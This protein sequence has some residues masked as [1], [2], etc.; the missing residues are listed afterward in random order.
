MS[1]L[2][3]VRG[4]SHRF[5]GLEV[6]KDVSFKIDAGSI[7]GLI[8]PNGAGKST[9]FNIISGFLTP[10]AGLVLYDGRDVSGVPV[11][12][13]SYA[14]LVRTF[15]TPQVF[16]HL[17]V[18]ENLIAGGYKQTRSGMLANLLGTPPSRADMARMR[19]A[20]DEACERFG[21]TEVRHR[22]AGKLPGGQQRL[23][24]LAR[25]WVGRPR[26]LCLDEPSS[27]LNSEEVAHLMQI[28]IALN[29]DGMT[30][31]LVS[32]DMEL[33][34]VAASIHVL[35]FGEIIA[36]GPLPAI[37]ADARVREAYLGS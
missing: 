3:E 13:R 15:Q 19:S 9:L 23:L 34:S 36:S 2:L 26:L 37:Q 20:A 31:L 14:G 5:R 4:I 35:C 17:S 25:A 21:L 32:H 30:I 29:R 11:P 33:V 7:A 28:L 12:A 27:G 1:A 22:P 6:L 16:G 10:D 24:E 18:L 8:G